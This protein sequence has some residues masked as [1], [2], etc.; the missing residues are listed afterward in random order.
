M[1]KKTRKIRNDG[2]ALI[3]FSDDAKK[4]KL[5]LRKASGGN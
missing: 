1:R 2:G 5:E 3:E 4:R